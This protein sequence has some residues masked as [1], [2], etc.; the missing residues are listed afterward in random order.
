MMTRSLAENYPYSPVYKAN[1]RGA[2]LEWLRIVEGIETNEIAPE[3]ALHY[4]LSQLL[5]RATAFK[6]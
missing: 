5:N 3:P 2:R 1:I 6:T 4:L